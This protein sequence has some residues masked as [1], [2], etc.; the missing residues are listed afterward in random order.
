MNNTP[1]AE[2][3]IVIEQSIV[4]VLFQQLKYACVGNQQNQRCLLRQSP[5]D[6]LHMVGQSKN[7]V[8]FVQVSCHR[9]VSLLMPLTF[10]A[11]T[12]GKRDTNSHFNFVLLL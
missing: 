12:S 10:T 4:H 5:S 11:Y 6:G 9:I 8:L 7:K 1:S 3:F 2:Q